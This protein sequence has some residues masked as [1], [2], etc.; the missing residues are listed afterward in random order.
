MTYDLHSIAE[1]AGRDAWLSSEAANVMALHNITVDACKDLIDLGARAVT[2][3]ILAELGKQGAGWRPI[4][5]APKDGTKID[6]WV[7][8]PE[9]GE[10][11]RATNAY[12]HEDRLDWWI[13]GYCVNQYAHCPKITHWMPL[14]PAPGEQAAPSA[15]NASPIR[16]EDI[17]EVAMERFWESQ[18]GTPTGVRAV[19]EFAKF[20]YLDKRDEAIARD[21]AVATWVKAALHTLTG[22]E[23]D[24]GEPLPDDYEIGRI[25]ESRD[26]P[27]FRLRVGHLRQLQA[28]LQDALPASGAKV[29]D[30]LTTIAEFPVT[31]PANQDA[32]NMRAIAHAALI[33]EEG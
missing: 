13:D 18:G 29:R 24:V 16:D 31:D 23:R 2:E 30:A 27:S 22:Y 14:P 15:R 1:Q 19:L 17:F 21:E 9:H 11:R 10:S 28:L 32:A 6:L 7:Y 4:E 25:E 5:T 33:G 20:V 3:A 26:A 12:W 8:W